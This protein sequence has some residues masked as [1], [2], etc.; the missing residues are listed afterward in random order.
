[1]APPPLTSVTVVTRLQPG[2]AE[3][4]HV[5]ATLSAFLDR[6]SSLPLARACAVGSV[7]LLERIWTASKSTETAVVPWCQP[8]N[9]WRP[10]RMLWTNRYYYQD[11]FAKGMIE[12]C[13]HADA[14]TVQ[15][16]VEHFSSCVVPAQA[17]EA[18][19]Q[20]GQREILELLLKVHGDYK[21]ASMPGARARAENK[22]HQ[23]KFWESNALLAAAT[24]GHGDLVVWMYAD[25]FNGFYMQS[26]QEVMD[27]LA[28]HG[29]M[30]AVRRLVADRWQPPRLDFA[31]EGV[32][33]AM[34]QWL[35]D[36][37]KDVGK[38]WALKNAAGKGH[39]EVVKLLTNEGLV[40]LDGQ[41]FCDAATHGHLAVVQWLK[42][43]NLGWNM[44]YKAIDLAAA[45]GHLEVVRYLHEICSAVCTHK[46]MRAAASNGHLRVV[47]WLHAQFSEDL[48]VDL[49]AAGTKQQFNTTV[50]D[51]AAMNGHLHV[52]KYLHD[53]ALAM[54]TVDLL[55]ESTGAT[56]PTCTPAAIQF[57]AAGG[58]LEVL[59]WL[60]VNYWTEPLV[61]VMDVAASSGNLAMVKWLHEHSASK[62][63][64]AAMDG[65]ASEGHLAVVQWL[66]ENRSEGCTVKA[67]DDAAAMGHLEVVQWLSGHRTEGC[68]AKALEGAVSADH[69]D[70]A[71]FLASECPGLGCVTEHDFIDNRYISSWMEEEYPQQ[72]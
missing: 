29:D 53:V 21:R 2:I 4:S 5:T 54:E 68:S 6:S 67:M 58:H 3:L 26:N 65:A 70:V 31:A 43:N 36:Q 16:L 8:T 22:P 47:Q 37:H 32:N 64:S 57:A 33:V 72:E 48:S 24:G 19:A 46:T 18:A 27:Q 44:A 39:L 62:F 60:H 7:A 12:A 35:L 28:R 20:R 14:S 10:S 61:D 71:L 59:Q 23:V 56:V 66:H 25:V 30:E 55:Q 9:T 40:F 49:Y 34:V 52:L 42:E 38:E 45:N 15:W 50:M 63:S 11:Q 1:M 69:F 51:V 13:K 41:A 17:I